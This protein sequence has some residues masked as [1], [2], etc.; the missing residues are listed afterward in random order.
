MKLI[1]DWKNAWRWASINCMA[2][3]ASVQGAW[4]YIP[5]DLRDNVPHHLASAI[6]LVLLALGIIGR[7]TQKGNTNGIAD[8]DSK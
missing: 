7:I 6:T 3:A 4:M 1:D 5:D 8:T 2:L